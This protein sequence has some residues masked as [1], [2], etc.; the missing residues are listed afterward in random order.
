MVF[1]ENVCLQR[2]NILQ[3]EKERFCIFNYAII[4]KPLIVLLTA[5][6]LTAAVCKVATGLWQVH[7]SGNIA[8][9]VMLL[10][11]AMGHFKFTQGMTM[12]IPSVI[13]YKVTLVY[14]TGVAEIALGIALFFP[15]LRLVAGIALIT[16]LILL[17]PANIWA[18]MR[19]INF[20]TGGHGKGPSYLI[21]RIPL[22]LF[23]IGWIWYFAI[24]P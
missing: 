1:A 17:L 9:G 15:A 21:F 5:F 22:Q 16:L 13:P 14:L 3:N 20:E 24:R 7:A 6:G 10:F 23:F 19:Q 11:T 8:M 4:M 18:A 2:M 12:M